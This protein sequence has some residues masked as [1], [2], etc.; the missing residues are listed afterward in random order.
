MVPGNFHI[1]FHNYV[2]EFQNLLGKWIYQPD[3][4]HKIY[5]LEF[6]VV[7][8]KTKRRI[9]RNFPL[10]TLHTLNGESN[11]RLIQELGFPHGMTH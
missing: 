10:N 2:P 3:F 7:D 5:K 4:S 9:K 11:L 8:I 6:G 1:S